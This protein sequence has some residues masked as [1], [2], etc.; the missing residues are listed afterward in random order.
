MKTLLFVSSLML[1]FSVLASKARLEALGESANGSFY[2][3]DN[4]NIWFNPAQVLEHGDLVTYEFGKNTKNIESDGAVTPRAEG[5]IYKAHGEKVYGLHF[6]GASTLSNGMRGGAGYIN[7]DSSSQEENNLELFYGRDSGIKWGTSL[8]YSRSKGGTFG[9]LF[10][11]TLRARAGAIFG[12]SQ[13]FV[14]LDLINGAKNY[15]TATTGAG[16]EVTRLKTHLPFEAGFIHE[17]RGH[18]LFVNYKQFL[19]ESDWGTF[20]GNKDLSYQELQI[21]MGRVLAVSEASSVFV[22][23]NYFQNRAHNGHGNITPTGNPAETFCDPSRVFY[24]EDF[25]TS[26]VPVV[27]GLETNASSWLILRASVTQVLW[28]TEEI[29]GDKR[30]VQNSTGVNAGA[31]LIWGDL[32]VDGVIGNSSGTAVGNDTASGNGTLRTD[33][34]LSRVS[35]TY[36]F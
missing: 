11:E 14:S 7:N 5:G 16:G 23:M 32:T 3:K 13:A 8:G 1:S 9:K 4:R 34:L 30:S 21:G 25:N 35:M 36:R 22:R 28:G 17:L 29:N 10:A 6:G 12:D 20:Y 24:C 15:G 31:S 27:L 19:A 2:F 18:T 33:S 26:R